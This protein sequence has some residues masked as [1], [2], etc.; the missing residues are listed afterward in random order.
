MADGKLLD[1]LVA[2][3]VGKNA[4]AFTPKPVLGED[5]IAI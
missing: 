5:P 3:N 1:E 4:I 2:T